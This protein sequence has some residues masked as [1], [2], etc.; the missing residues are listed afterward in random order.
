MQIENV[1]ETTENCRYCLMCRH[2]CPVGHVTRNESH[3]PHGWGLLIASEKRGLVD[4]NPTSVETL[5][6]CADC[7]TCRAN[8]VTDQPLPSAIAAA[9]AEVVGQGKA[10]PAVAAALERMEKWENPYQEVA[11]DPVQGSGE[12]AVYVSDEFRFLYP[13]GLEAALR[14]LSALGEDPALI[15]GGRN[16]GYL[17]SSLG[18][19]E[20]A[21]EFAKRNLE[22]LKT[23]GAKKLLVLAPGDYYSFQQLYPERLGMEFPS[24]IE[25]EELI[26]YLAE[27]TEGRKLKLKT[28]KAEGP[29]AYLDPTHSVRVPGRFQAPRRLLDSTLPDGRLEL[30]WRMERTHPCGNG[31]LQFS[32]PHIA[33][34]L[35]YSRLGDAVQVGAH[36]LYTEDAGCL[37]RLNQVAPRFGVQV[38]GLYEFLA[39][40]LE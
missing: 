37:H 23:S 3:T 26:V 9:R 21:G 18:H 34:H 15:G 22:E 8:C 16:N 14:I 10:P 13:T 40:Q 11:P 30:F 24:E 39:D 32:N 2:V 33:S 27:K 19:P 38:R 36:L 4:W 1:I 28:S 29:Y 20:L 31:A 5:Y 35:D 17:A 7:G 25:L 6:G 12:L